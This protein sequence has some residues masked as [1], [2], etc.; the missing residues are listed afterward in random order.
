M[1]RT[2]TITNEETIM[3]KNAN[4][5]AALENANRENAR[6]RSA[7]ALS[8]ADAYD[9]METLVWALGE[10][11]RAVTLEQKRAKEAE[12]TGRRA[13][14]LSTFAQYDDAAN[15]AFERA[16]LAPKFLKHALRDLKEHLLSLDDS[17]APSDPKKAKKVFE[18]FAKRFLQKNPE[19][20]RRVPKTPKR[21]A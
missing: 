14:D 19:L 8:W 1:T 2:D 20:A 16:G 9:A 11:R 21:A 15:D 13:L 5:T 3:K 12:E 17:K 10:A 18:S 6:L 4:T 7:L